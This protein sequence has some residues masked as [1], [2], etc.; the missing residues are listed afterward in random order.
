MKIQF[1]KNMNQ[2]SNYIIFNL[3][4]FYRIVVRGPFDD[5]YLQNVKP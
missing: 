5:S 3:I 2:K 4:N 1:K